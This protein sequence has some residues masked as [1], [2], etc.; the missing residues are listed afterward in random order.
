MDSGSSNSRAMEDQVKLLVEQLFTTEDLRA[1]QSLAVELQRAVY[2]YI[3][4]LQK[5]LVE[6]SVVPSDEQ[7]V[8]EIDLSDS[9]FDSP[10]AEPTDD[11]S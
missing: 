1:V 8:S 3:E 7:P 5:R 2:G 9:S 10:L 11:E 4:Q 6:A